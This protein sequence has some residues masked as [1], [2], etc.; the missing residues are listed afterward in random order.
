MTAPLPVEIIERR[1]PAYE[2]LKSYEVPAGL[3][4]AGR[5]IVV[6]DWN[7]TPVK[8]FVR[9][10]SRHI[11]SACIHVDLYEDEGKGQAGKFRTFPVSRVL[12]LGN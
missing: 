6:Q 7:G 10:V 3:I 5:I 2:H 11:E 1:P 12:K 9:S 4:E 8:G